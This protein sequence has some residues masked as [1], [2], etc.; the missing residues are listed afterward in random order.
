MSDSLRRTS[1]SVIERLNDAP[2]DF[3][4]NQALKILEHEAS[5]SDS[6]QQQSLL[7][8]FNH[9]ANEKLRLQ[10]DHSLAF[11]AGD[12][13]KIEQDKNQRWKLRNRLFSLTGAQG[14][15]PYTFTESIQA[16]QKQKD[17]NLADFLNVFS[18]RAS[19]L[20]YKASCKYRAERQYEGGKLGGDDTLSLMLEALTGIATPN[21]KQNLGLDADTMLFYA[22]IFSQSVRTASG[23]KHL[24]A[25]HF[26]V[27]IGI[28]QFQGQWQEVV[29]SGRS[30]LPSRLQPKGQNVCL[31]RNTM[32]GER[33]W[34]AQ[35]KVSIV[36]RPRAAEVENFS[37][38][39]DSVAAMHELIKLYLGFEADF[40]LCVEIPPDA[41]QQS[42]AL[43][44][45]DS[46]KLSW[47]SWLGQRSPEQQTSPKAR[48]V[49]VSPP[50]SQRTL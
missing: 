6:A 3:E 7:G 29:D 5:D 15:M 18:H 46:G 19:S 17:G 44:T 49:S 21:L 26:A 28:E 40:E 11:P 32:L 43:G 4:F 14:V 41:K 31:G 22:G 25:E 1:P 48:R 39:S 8:G 35:D 34:V 16:R 13:A 30:R 20:F 24:L 47:N 33:G 38:G 27:D 10:N 45:A 23:L 36:V 42:A 2:Q 50:S 9:P 12:I 37:P